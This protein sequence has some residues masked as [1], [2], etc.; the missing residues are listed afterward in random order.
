MSLQSPTLNVVCTANFI[1]ARQTS[2]ATLNICTRSV[3][4]ARH[5]LGTCLTSTSLTGTRACSHYPERFYYERKREET[6]KDDV[7]LFKAGEDAAETFQPAE[8]PFD[9]IALL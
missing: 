8:Q 5:R 2:T 4:R 6:K 1:D 9:F 7:E 3:T